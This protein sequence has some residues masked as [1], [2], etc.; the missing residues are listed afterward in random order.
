MSLDY[1]SEY[2]LKLGCNEVIREKLIAMD[3]G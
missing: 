3:D 1:H 2:R